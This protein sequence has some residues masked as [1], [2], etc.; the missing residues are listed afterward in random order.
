MQIPKKISHGDEFK[1]STMSRINEIIEYLKTQR[2]SGD[3][4]TVVV[5]QSCSGVSISALPSPS[6]GGGVATADFDHPFKIYFTSDAEGKQQVCIRHG[7][8]YKQTVTFTF[9]GIDFQAESG[10]DGNFVPF[11]W[12]TAADEIFCLVGVAYTTDAQGSYSCELLVCNGNIL[13]QDIPCLSGYF[14]FYIGAIQKTSTEEGYTLSVVDQRLTNDLI[15]SDHNEFYPF[16]VRC[17]VNHGDT[18]ELKNDYKNFPV[19]T[20]VSNGGRITD[21]NSGKTYEVIDKGYSPS[22]QEGSVYCLLHRTFSNSG[23]KWEILWEE[24]FDKEANT[25]DDCKFPIALLELGQG[26]TLY[27]FLIGDLIIGCDTYKIKIDDGLNSGLP[28]KTPDFIFK[29]LRGDYGSFFGQNTPTKPNSE[30]T[31]PGYMGVWYKFEK[32]GGSEEADFGTLRLA[33]QFDK[34]PSYTEKYLTL[35]CK[36]GLPVWEEQGKI[37]VTAEDSESKFLPEVLKAGE[38]IEIAAKDG[39]FTIKA[40]PPVITGVS[41]I[42]VKTTDKAGWEFEVKL[43]KNFVEKVKA[44]NCITVGGSDTEPEISVDLDC[45]FSNLSIT[46]TAPIQVTGSKDTWNIGLAPNSVIT[47]VANGQCIVTSVSNG[48]ATIGVDKTCIFSNFSISGGSGISVSGS[49][50][51]WTVSLSKTFVESVSAGDCI[52]VT[53]GKNPQISVDKDCVFSDFKIE[54]VSPIAVSGSGRK[55][56]ISID[57]KDLIKGVKEGDCIKIDTQDGVAEI[58]VDKDCVFQN[59][60]IVGDAYITAAGSKDSWQLSLNP[61]VFG[62]VKVSESDTLD[63][64]ENQFYNNDLVNFQS[65]GFEISAELGSDAIVSGDKSLD[66]VFSNGG[67]DIRDLG[68]AAVSDGDTPG[69]LVEKIVVDPNLQNFLNVESTGSQLNIKLSATGSGLMVIQN[70]SISVLSIPGGNYVLGANNGSLS[71]LPYSECETACTDEGY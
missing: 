41:P 60:S 65:N 69:F 11:N 29:K 7:R 50:Q 66:V 25:H 63:F 30:E 23:E 62:K 14:P 19:Q 6:I 56:S 51:S 42:S 53:G 13:V 37:R 18:K 54:G 21:I 61:A 3:N 48:I 16:A 39:E 55:W 35:N 34:I 28:D 47:G 2:I 44:G 40:L 27:Q 49:G 17:L 9:V 33:W 70:G 46:G 26:V 4:R 45:V 1:S 68:K 67:Y 38:H 71:W 58:S 20:A 12:E 8:V 10:A 5:N 22:E 36:D 64:L 15:I 57:T 32:E 52:K 43:E 31:L 59:F 24:E